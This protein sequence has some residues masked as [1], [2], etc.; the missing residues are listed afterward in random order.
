[1]LI[2]PDSVYEERQRLWR[3]REDGRLTDEAFYRQLLVLDPDDFMGLAGLAGVF[4]DAGDPVSAEQYYWRAIVA[5]PCASSPYLALAQLL[6]AQPESRALA[7]GLSELGILK[8]LREDDG[9][10]HLG[11]LLRKLLEDTPAPAAARDQLTALPAE[12]LARLLALSL[13]EN[14]ESEPEPVTEILRLP[15]LVE[16][17]LD[18]SDMD[19]AMVDAF[20]AEGEK[21]APFLTGVVRAWV[22]DFLNEDGDVDVENALGLLGETGTSAEIPCLLELVDLE[23]NVASGA[24]SWAVGRIMDRLPEEAARFLESIIPSLGVP[25]RL[26]I[27]ELLI[28]RDGFD[29]GNRLFGRLS[30][31]MEAME[32][33]ERDRYLPLL[34]VSMAANPRRG[35]VRTARAILRA[36]G[37]LVSRKARRECEELVSLFDGVGAPPAPVPPPAPTIYE[38]CAG[39]AIWDSDEDDEEEEEDDF[40]PPEPVRRSAAPGRNDLCWCN[41]GKK[42]KKCHL[43]SD[44]RESRSSVASDTNEFARLRRS[45]V[46]FLGQVLHPAEMKDAFAEF[47]GD[48]VPGDPDDAKM[49]VT[50]WT[51]HDWIAP[52]LGRTVLEQFLMERGARLTER[53]REM[54]AAWSRSFVS[55]YEIQKLKPGAGA[56]LKEVF[57]GETFFVH[58]VNLS[59]SATKWDGL[60]T[61]VVPG[62]RGIE[63]AAVAQSVPRTHLSPLREWMEDDRDERGLAWPEYL[64]ANWPRIRRQANEIAEGWLDRLQ[65]ANSSGEELLFSKAVYGILDEGKVIGALRRSAEF[66]EDATG[67]G[68]RQRFVWLNDKQTV[69]GTIGIADGELS[70]ESNSRQRHER[71]K[72]LIAD[73]AGAGVR[74]LR[75]EFTTQKEMKRR[76]KEMPRNSKD[77]GDEI[78]ADVRNEVLTKFGEQHYREWLDTGLPGLGGKTPREAAKSPKGRRQ[79]AE[80]L[81]FVENTEDRKR[82]RGE[83]FIEM[84]RIRADLGLD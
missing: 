56:E 83:P 71:G 60:L 62:E 10:G 73:L 8:Q 23:N 36:K 22:R 54:A 48:G 27:A 17:L 7:S 72:R 52:R 58:D 84:A 81:K 77:A 80:V 53:E 45:L 14:R 37:A 28:A 2:L 64:K 44:E 15:R 82:Q 33:D 1:M 75:D 69:L 63:L 43:E 78:P 32:Q 42:Y 49:S 57:S 16:D 20:I 4:R 67:D 21:I 65:L 68:S 31:D 74:H 79:L 40:L 18:T 76:A 55:L 35:G 47:F 5:N 13:R 39:N 3:E 70:F 25:Q 11:D 59:R 41:S 29:P 50:E 30:E 61:R 12:A 66:T 24:S 9:E 38:I 51:I 19:A 26:K 46:E 6:H 34:L